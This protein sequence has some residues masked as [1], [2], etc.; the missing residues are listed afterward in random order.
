[1]ASWNN[2]A[3]HVYVQSSENIQLTSFTEADWMEN[4][5]II[6]ITTN[7]LL[8]H[9]CLCRLHQQKD[10]QVYCAKLKDFWLF[11]FT[12]NII[13]V[14]FFTLSAK[15]L[16]QTVVYGSHHLSVF[17]TIVATSYRLYLH[18]IFIYLYKL[19]LPPLIK[20]EPV[21]VTSIRLCSLREG[22]I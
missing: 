11:E 9:I 5:V 14:T 20:N 2:K 17:I 15:L 19:L 7:N 8:F 1:M 13:I 6:N 4:I 12:C 21:Q 10:Y 22:I 3:L 18:N 16:Y